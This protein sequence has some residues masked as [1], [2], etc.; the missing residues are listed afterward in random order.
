MNRR[1]VLAAGALLIVL[2]ASAATWASI[3][4]RIPQDA[5][6]P[7][8]TSSAGPY[9]FAGELFVLNH[10]EW[11]AIPFWRPLSSVPLDFNLFD[12]ADPD[13]FGNPNVPL[14]VEG[15]AI[16][17]GTVPIGAPAISE[18]RGTGAVP[19]V[20][21][22]LADLEAASAD[23]EL[24]ICELLLLDTRIGTATFYQE[25]NHTTN[26]PVS[27]LTVVATGPLEGGSTFTLMAVEVA[28]ELQV[29]RIQFD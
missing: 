29:V 16:F 9:F 22:K 3:R 18:T 17:H 7:I 15:F 27:H 11:A 10:G 12:W 26:N 14:L 13:L 20:F 1:H 19:V 23:G 24:T 2:L 5:Q 4:V 8:Y 21:V 6:P 25:Q 28:L